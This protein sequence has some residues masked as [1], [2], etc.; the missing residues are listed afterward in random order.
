MTPET[1]ADLATIADSLRTLAWIATAWALVQ[2]AAFLLA[3]T[4]EDRK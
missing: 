3:V 1:A 2:F 4:S